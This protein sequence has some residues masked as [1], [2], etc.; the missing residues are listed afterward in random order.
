MFEPGDKVVHIRHGAGVV[1]ETRT[2]VYEGKERIYFC[3]QLNDARH[4]LMIP[5]ENVDTEELRP[6]LV[7]TQLIEEVLETA[8]LELS[9]N[10]RARQ[11]DIRDKLK[12]RNPRKLTQALRDLVWLEHTHK[13]TNTDIRLRDSV[14]TAL[15]RELALRP[16]TSIRNAQVTIMDLVNKAV[17]SHL[18]N[19]PEIVSAS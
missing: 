18:A 17:Q 4:T 15:A 10:F 19:R 14:L 5:V 1:I 8:P 2:L 7:G 16:E 13:L 12:S 3:I 11:S 6:A 9:D